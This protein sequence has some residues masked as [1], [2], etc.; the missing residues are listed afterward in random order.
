[1]LR[2]DG[3]RRA[4]L[5]ITA[6]VFV[7]IAAHANVRPQAAHLG[8]HLDDVDA[9]NEF[10]AIYLG[11]WLATAV[12]LVIAARR[13]RDAILGDLGAL[14]ILGQVLGRL[15][16]LILDGLPGPSI[17]AIGSLELVGGLVILAVRPG[18]PATG[19]A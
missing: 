7:L 17:W 2:S 12:M 13:V 18:G 4:V 9:R 16:S 6:A 15:V 3:L 11:L 8:R 1:L 14:L 10:R 19:R 5:L